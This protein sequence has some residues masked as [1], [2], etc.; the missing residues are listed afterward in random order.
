MILLAR[1]EGTERMNRIMACI[2]ISGQNSGQDS[3]LIE[4]TDSH[5]MPCSVHS[6]AV[7]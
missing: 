4:L 2:I 7:L 3:L 1:P 5:D 6:S